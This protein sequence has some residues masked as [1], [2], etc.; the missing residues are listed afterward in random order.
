MPSDEAVL[1]APVH[2]ANLAVFQHDG[3]ADLGVFDEHVMIDRGK[4]PDV[5]VDD[6]RLFADDAGPRMT[7]LMTSA[8][9]SIVT[10]LSTSEP[11]STQPSTC[12]VS[13]SSTR[14][15]AS[16]ISPGFPVSIHHPS[17]Y[18]DGRRGRARPAIGWRR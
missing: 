12:G 16:S 3:A 4:R 2:V 5:G 1:N 14:L 15:L 11:R 18:R 8:P 6:A 17:G 13:S 9:F 10:R 7:L